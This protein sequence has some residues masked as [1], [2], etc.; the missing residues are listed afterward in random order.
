M[1]RK[2]EPKLRHKTTSKRL[3][4]AMEQRLSRVQT[5]SHDA[6]HLDS[7]PIMHRPRSLFVGTVDVEKI[8]IEGRETENDV[9]GGG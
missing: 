5:V 1:L 9:V 6:L 7:I 2:R 8:T 4:S 3:V